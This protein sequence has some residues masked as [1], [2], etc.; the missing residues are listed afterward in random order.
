MR[1]Q[2]SPLFIMYSELEQ[3]I[4]SQVESHIS[5]NPSLFLVDVLIKGNVGNQKVMVFIDGDDGVSIDDCAGISRMLGQFLES[6][7]AIEGKYLLDVSS[8]GLDH[9][10][11]LPRQYKRNLG[12][13]VEVELNNEKL[14]GILKSFENDRIVISDG[15]KEKEMALKDVKQTKV[16]V[17]FK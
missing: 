12:R 10:L 17:S 8:P 15:K 2:E 16:L 3:K 9:P 7:D 1:G 5:D 14:K 11:K 4:I 6:E 13:E